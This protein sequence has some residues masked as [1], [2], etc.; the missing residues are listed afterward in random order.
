MDEVFLF[1]FTYLSGLFGRVRTL[2][3]DFLIAKHQ[4]S[5][6]D[7]GLVMLQQESPRTGTLV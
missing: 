4:A 5:K 3:F 7:V 2:K 1:V 6:F